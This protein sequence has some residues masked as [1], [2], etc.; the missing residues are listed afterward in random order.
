MLCPGERGGSR[1]VATFS[2][3]TA[4]PDGELLA[5]YRVGATKDSAGSVTEI[6]RSVDGG[7]SWGTPTAPFAYEFG[8][9]QG[10]L[11]VV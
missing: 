3:L 7:Q 2:S 9:V 5:M 1:A 10:S 4:L 6:R 8:G 11:Q